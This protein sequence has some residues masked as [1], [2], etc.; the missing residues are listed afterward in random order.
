MKV[1]VPAN[2]RGATRNNHV[3]I[4]S[5][6]KVIVCVL[7]VVEWAAIDAAASL[8]TLLLDPSLD[9]TST[10]S[11]PRFVRVV[12]CTENPRIGGCTLAAQGAGFDVVDF[13]E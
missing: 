11:A 9:V 12:R 2:Q 6:D 10:E 7:N 13:E 4:C 5:P 8:F 3:R 1:G